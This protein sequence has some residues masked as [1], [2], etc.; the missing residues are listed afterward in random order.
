MPVKSIDI[1][2]EESSTNI[3]INIIDDGLAE[4]LEMFTV[5][6]HASPVG[7][8]FSARQDIEVEIMDNEGMLCRSSSAG[9][10]VT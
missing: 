4:A 5:S 1:L 2:P 7:H 10:H 9:L 3:S 6:V 8:V